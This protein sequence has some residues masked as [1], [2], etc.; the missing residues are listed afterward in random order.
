MCRSVQSSIK[1]PYH[2][3]LL[4]EEAKPDFLYMRWDGRILDFS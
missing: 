4:R 1:S 3:L 2:E